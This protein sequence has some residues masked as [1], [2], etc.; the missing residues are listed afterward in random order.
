MVFAPISGFALMDSVDLKIFESTKRVFIVHKVE[1]KESVYSIS[2]RYGIEV[3]SLYAFNPDVKA[4][5]LKVDQ[6][7]FITTKYNMKQGDWLIRKRAKEKEEAAKIQQLKDDGLAKP[8]GPNDN[9]IYYKAKL[10]QTLYAISKLEQCQFTVDELKKWNNLKS[11]AISEGDK[12]II[13]F[14][15]EPIVDDKPD[16][17][18]VVEQILNGKDSVEQIATATAKPD[19]AKVVWKDVQKEGLAT[20]KPNGSLANT[21]A[22]AL[23][24][25]AKPGTVIRVLNL[26]NQ[27]VSY[28]RVAGPIVNAEN[29]DVILIVSES[30]AKKLGVNDNYFRVRIIYATEDI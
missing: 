30:A 3:D 24:N 13:G 5:G 23:Y 6:Y 11:S 28:V 22:F 1:A 7:V 4:N 27:K 8:A 17:P 14:R 19:T 15:K 26:N 9:V 18:K 12:L 25:G 20:W 21:K 10:G 29:K 16:D 2:K